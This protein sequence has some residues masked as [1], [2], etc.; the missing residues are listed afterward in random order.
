ME[1]IY[2]RRRPSNCGL[3][4]VLL[5]EGRMMLLTARILIFVTFGI[6]QGSHLGTCP[7]YLYDGLFP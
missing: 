7:T 1:T 4:F 6:L 2:G 3:L 5:K